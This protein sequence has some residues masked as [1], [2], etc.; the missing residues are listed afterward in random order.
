MR[1]FS[2]SEASEA[3][4]SRRMLASQAGIVVGKELPDQ[5]KTGD[6]TTENGLCLGPRFWPAKIDIRCDAVEVVTQGSEKSR[7]FS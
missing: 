6:F 7:E 2:R 4:S 3:R 1:R 5:I